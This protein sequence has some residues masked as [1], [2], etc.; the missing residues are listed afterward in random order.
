MP[1]W[2]PPHKE[3]TDASVHIV[4]AE[5]KGLAE[6]REQSPL[7]P[8][9]PRILNAGLQLVVF[10]M[11]LVIVGLLTHILR[12][13][14]GSRGIHFGTGANDSWP[15]DLNLVP[16]Y[17]FLALAAASVLIALVS[18][19]HQVWLIKRRYHA[20][21]L[22]EGASALTA[23]L[24][25]VFWLTADGIQAKSEGT[26]KKD[27]LKWAC[28]RSSSPT[29]VLVSYNSICQEQVCDLNMKKIVP[30]LFLLPLGLD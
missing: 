3:T 6:W 29:N 26:P 14:S 2:S 15:S 21:S 11:A 28:K 8:R 22:G 16:A 4:P 10:I 13:Y 18:A 5:G 25:F 17:T 19:L 27:L 24:A 7:L 1:F 30:G 23:F 20:F 9:W 12:K